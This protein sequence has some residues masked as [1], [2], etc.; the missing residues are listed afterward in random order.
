MNARVVP[1]LGLAAAL[2]ACDSAIEPG[3]TN[4]ALTFRYDG[5]NPAAAAGPGPNASAAFVIEGTDGATL[6]V[7]DVRLVLDELK[8]EREQDACEG[9]DEV[10][11]QLDDQCARFQSA[12]LFLPVPTARDDVATVQALVTEGTY[13]SLKL[14]TKAPAD[15]S[16]LLE[17]IEADFQEWPGQ[18]SAVVMGIYTPAGGGEPRTFTAYFDAEVKVTMILPE[19]FVVE[20]GSEAAITVFVDPAIWFVD[21]DGAVVDLSAFD[22]DPANPVVPKLEAKFEEMVTKIEVER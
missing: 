13:V 14:E 7:T 8:L 5:A 1:V 2:S 3:Q 17:A 20:A 21:A 9:L 22:F 11:H 15:G 10:P 6:E 12:P 16:P 18:A 4:V 19:P